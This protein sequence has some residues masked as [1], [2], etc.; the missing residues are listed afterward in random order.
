TRV[1]HGLPHDDCPAA[2]RVLGRLAVERALDSKRAD[3]REERKARRRAGL[4]GVPHEVLIEIEQRREIGLQEG[5][6]DLVRARS[7]LEA[8]HHLWCGCPAETAET[9]L[10]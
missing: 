4:D 9:G 10:A 2:R 7:R 3:V 6:T 8:D 5:D 1:V